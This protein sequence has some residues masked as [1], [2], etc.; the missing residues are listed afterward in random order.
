MFFSDITSFTTCAT[1]D[2]F[3]VVYPNSKGIC[4]I[5]TKNNLYWGRIERN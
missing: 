5:H 2:Y 3:I 1:T 4:N